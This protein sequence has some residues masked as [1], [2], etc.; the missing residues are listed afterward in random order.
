MGIKDF[1]KKIFRKNNLK[2][3]PE[4]VEPSHPLKFY[5]SDGDYVMLTNIK[6]EN[7][8]I[9]NSKGN[10]NLYSANL[11]KQNRED[12]TYAQRICFEIPKDLSVQ[13]MQN[14]IQH[15]ISTV[16]NGKQTTD[17]HRYD[18]TFSHIGVINYDGYGQF[19][20]NNPKQIALEWVENNYNKSIRENKYYSYNERIE[21]SNVNMQERMEFFYE[22][23]EKLKRDR[24][25]TKVDRWYNPIL[26]MDNFYSNTYTLYQQ[27]ELDD[28]EQET[29]YS[30]LINLQCIGTLLKDGVISYAYSADLNNYLDSDIGGAG[31]LCPVYPKICFELPCLFENVKERFQAGDKSIVQYL[32]V[33]L[34]Q[35]NLNLKRSQSTDAKRTYL[36]AIRST[37]NGLFIDYNEPDVIKSYILSELNKSNTSKGNEYKNIRDENR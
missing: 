22:Q 26:Y 25:N 28:D 15:L 1:L 5:A 4:Y 35:E 19:I 23:N 24:Y 13:E 36:G 20:L 33:L 9:P 29:G 16:Y 32:G 17:I 31:L 27:P 18:G 14:Q 12:T 37:E 10:T 6:K 11:I 8:E 7:L 2:G 30:N 3:L 34:R 21:K